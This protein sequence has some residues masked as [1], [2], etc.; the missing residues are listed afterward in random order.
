MLLMQSW[1]ESCIMLKPKNIKLLAL[2]TFKAS[3][4]AYS[5]LLNSFW[6]LFLLII[7]IQA[8]CYYPECIFKGDWSYYIVQILKLLLYAIMCAVARP[9]LALKNSAYLSIYIFRCLITAC[10]LLLL[11]AMAQV[12]FSMLLLFATFFYL[13]SYGSWQDLLLSLVRSIVMFMYNLPMC[14]FS[15]G[16]AFLWYKGLLLV[17]GVSSSYFCPLVMPLALAW[18]KNIYVKRLHD[19]FNIYYTV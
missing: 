5:I 7:V 18:V 9:S 3:K 8:S 1:K 6:W 10:L 14:I 13:D 2:V 16:V 17:F 4:Q 19:Q 15:M 11:P 12:S